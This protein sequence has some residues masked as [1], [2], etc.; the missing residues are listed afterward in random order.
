[1]FNVSLLW[2][3]T[4]ESVYTFGLVFTLLAV[5]NAHRGLFGTALVGDTTY[6]L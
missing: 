6:N 1:M 2:L 4:L 3:K 5:P